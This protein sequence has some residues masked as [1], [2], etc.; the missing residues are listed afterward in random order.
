MCQ[1]VLG[2]GWK[3]G[4]MEEWKRGGVEEWKNG[5]ME[6]GRGGRMEGWI[7]PLIRCVYL[8]IMI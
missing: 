7:L 2:E 6:E 5:R 1:T 4:R 3:N 8:G